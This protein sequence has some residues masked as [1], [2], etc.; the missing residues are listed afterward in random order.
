MF[1]NRKCVALNELSKKMTSIFWIKKP[2]LSLNPS[3][4]FFFTDIFDLTNMFMPK[5]NENKV[6]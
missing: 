2:F 1:I 3:Y 5:I 6:N 4:N